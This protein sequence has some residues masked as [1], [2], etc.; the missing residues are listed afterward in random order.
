M[1]L[2]IIDSLLMQG[3]LFLLQF[4]ADVEEILPPLLLLDAFQVVLVIADDSSRTFLERRF[5]TE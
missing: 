2:A 4:Q 1:P 5:D 3:K